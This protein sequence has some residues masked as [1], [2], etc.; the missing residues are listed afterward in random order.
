M[1]RY[2]SY[3]PIW[4]KRASVRT[5]PR[6]LLSQEELQDCYYFPPAQQPV[7]LHPLIKSSELKEKVLVY[8]LYKY[9]NDIANIEKDIINQIALKISKN[10]YEISFTRDIRQDALSIIIDESYHAYV[11]LDYCNQVAIKTGIQPLA[12]P[13]ET[14][15]S[16]SMKDISNRLP[17]NAKDS[18]NL[19]AT[20][21]A[22]H[23]LTNDL[24]IVAKS[25]EVCRTFF[26]IMQDHAQDE[27]RH[28]KYFETLLKIFWDFLSDDLRA[29]IGSVLPELIHQ[30]FNPSLQIQYDRVVLSNLGLSEVDVETIIHDTYATWS[31][32]TIS[33][34]NIVAKQMIALLRRTGV[35]EEPA[36][37][38][39]FE[40]YHVL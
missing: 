35:F 1:N 3:Q 32:D 8:S 38:S 33:E 18:F 2:E 9:L 39:Q 21:I 15:L 26:N 29:T 22:E 37:K 36:V 40:K 10:E 30:Y 23:A 11:A 12:L 24:I 5:K 31:E 17:E 6:R 27:G 34:T 4:E 20:C 16:G 13:T 19:I 25:K 7:A 14:A 28:A